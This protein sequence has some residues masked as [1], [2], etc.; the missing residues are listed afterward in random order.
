MQKTTTSL[1]IPPLFTDITIYHPLFPFVSF[2]SVDNPQQNT[3]SLINKTLAPSQLALSAVKAAIDHR[4]TNSP[5]SRQSSL[6]RE[7][8]ISPLTDQVPPSFSPGL[9]TPIL[10]SKTQ[11]ST[12]HQSISKGTLTRVD[13]FSVQSPSTPLPLISQGFSH[14][15]RLPST[16]SLSSTKQQRT[17]S[18]FELCMMQGITSNDAGKVSRSSR[19]SLIFTSQT[20]QKP[21]TDTVDEKKASLVHIL[22]SSFNLLLIL[23]PFLI[24]ESIL[25]LHTISLLPSSP[26]ILSKSTAASFINSLFSDPD[27][28]AFVFSITAPGLLPRITRKEDNTLESSKPQ[29]STPVPCVF[30]ELV[31]AYSSL[32]TLHNTDVLRSSSCL[33]LVSSQIVRSAE[34]AKPTSPPANR[35]LY[36]QYRLNRPKSPQSSVS[37]SSSGE[38]ATSTPLK[39]TNPVLLQIPSAF[40]FIFPFGESSDLS[41]NDLLVAVDVS[42][43]S[44][45]LHSLCI[46]RNRQDSSRLGRHDPGSITS[47]HVSS[48]T[49]DY[50]DMSS[51]ELAVI[52]KA[53]PFYVNSRLKQVKQPTISTLSPPDEN[54]SDDQSIN[55]DTEGV[56]DT[57]S[58]AQFVLVFHSIPQSFFRHLVSA[59]LHIATNMIISNADTLSDYRCPL[60]SPHTRHPSKPK[61]ETKKDH[62]P[63]PPSPRRNARSD[64]IGALSGAKLDSASLAL[65][66]SASIDLPFAKQTAALTLPSQTNQAPSPVASSPVVAPTAATYPRPK[67]PVQLK[68]N[69]YE[70]RFPKTLSFYSALIYRK[71]IHLAASCE[72]QD[73]LDIAI[74]SFSRVV[75]DSVQ[76]I[77]ST[78]TVSSQA[79]TD[80]ETLPDQSG[81]LNPPDDSLQSPSTGSGP[82]EA[83]TPGQSP[84]S[85]ISSSSSAQ[86]SVSFIS[87]ITQ[88]L[89][90]V[91]FSLTSSIS[92]PHQ[93]PVL[94]NSM[95]P[96]SDALS[97]NATINQAVSAYVLSTEQLFFALSLVRTALLD[98][99]Q[100]KDSWFLIY[101]VLIVAAR[102]IIISEPL[103]SKDSATF[104]S[105]FRSFDA[106]TCVFSRR[107][108]IDS[109]EKL[110]GIISTHFQPT[111]PRSSSA[112]PSAEDETEQTETHMVSYA[113]ISS[114]NSNLPPET[115]GSYI[116][117]IQNPIH[118]QKSKF[119]FRITP[120][121][122]PTVF[123]PFSS[124]PKPSPITSQEHH[125]VLLCPFCLGK[126]S[127]ARYCPLA[128]EPVEPSPLTV[129]PPTNAQESLPDPETILPQSPS[130]TPSPEMSEPEADYSPTDTFGQLLNELDDVGEEKVAFTFSFAS[131]DRKKRQS[132]AEDAMYYEN[133]VLKRVSS[134]ESMNNHS[135]SD[136]LNADPLS[137]SKPGQIKEF[138]PTLARDQFIDSFVDTSRPDLADEDAAISVFS[139]GIKDSL[140]LAC[141]SEQF[142]SINQVVFKNANVFTASLDE[143]NTLHLSFPTPFSAQPGEPADRSMVL[144][145]L[146]VLPPIEPSR[147]TEH[148]AQT[149][150][151]CR[152]LDLTRWNIHR[153]IL[154]LPQLLSLFRILSCSL[155]PYLRIAAVESV[156]L[157][158]DHAMRFLTYNEQNLIALFGDE[159]MMNDHQRCTIKYLLSFLNLLVRSNPFEDVRKHCFIVLRDLCDRWRSEFNEQEYDV[160]VSTIGSVLESVNDTDLKPDFITEKETTLPELADTKTTRFPLPDWPHPGEEIGVG[161]GPFAEVTSIHGP[162][163]AHI[164]LVCVDRITVKMSIELLESQHE[165]MVAFHR[166]LEAQP[167]ILSQTIPLSPTPLSESTLRSC[168]DLA[169]FIVLDSLEFLQPEHCVS[170]LTAIYAILFQV[171]ILQIQLSSVSVFTTIVEH[172]LTTHITQSQNEATRSR[173]QSDTLTFWSAF[174][175]GVHLLLNVMCATDYD[176]RSTAI[177]FFSNL[178]HVFKITSQKDALFAFSLIDRYIRSCKRL[179]NNGLVYHADIQRDPFLVPRALPSQHQVP[180]NITNQ[181]E[182][183]LS[184]AVTSAIHLCHVLL[185]KIDELRSSPFNGQSSMTLLPC[186]QY[187]ATRDSFLNDIWTSIWL[188]LHLFLEHSLGGCPHKR[189]LFSPFNFAQQICLIQTDVSKIAVSDRTSPNELQCSLC[190]HLSS[191]AMSVSLL[192]APFIPRA[193]PSPVFVQPTQSQIQA[194][195]DHILNSIIVGSHLKTDKPFID[196]FSQSVF[197]ETKRTSSSYL[198]KEDIFI[199]H[200]LQA[201]RPFG[202]PPIFIQDPPTGQTTPNQDDASGKDTDPLPSLLASLSSTLFHIDAHRRY[203]RNLPHLSRSLVDPLITL[204]ILTSAS[205]R[206]FKIARASMSQFT[207]TLLGDQ[208][209]RTVPSSLFAKTG[210]LISTSNR[211][212]TEFA[213]LEGNSTSQ[214]NSSVK[215]KSPKSEPNDT[216][217]DKSV[218]DVSVDSETMSL[219]PILTEDSTVDPAV[220]TQPDEE[221]VHPSE[222]SERTEEAMPMSETRLEST[223]NESDLIDMVSETRPSVEDVESEAK[224]SGFKSLLEKKSEPGREDDDTI[225]SSKSEPDMST[226]THKFSSHSIQQSDV[227]SKD[228]PSDEEPAVNAWYNSCGFYKL[229]KAEPQSPFPCCQTSTAGESESEHFEQLKAVPFSSMFPSLS[230]HQDISELIVLLS[231]IYTTALPFPRAFSSQSSSFTDSVTGNT[232]HKYE[233]PS[234]GPRLPYEELI[235]SDQS[236]ASERSSHEDTQ[237]PEPLSKGA[238]TG[239]HDVTWRF[240]QSH[241]PFYPHPT[242]ILKPELI[243]LSTN[244]QT[245]PV[246]FESSYSRDSLSI[247]FVHLFSLHSLSFMTP[248]ISF[249]KEKE[250]SNEQRDSL[251][252]SILAA[253]WRNLIYAIQSYRTLMTAIAGIG[254]PSLSVT[255][256]SIEDYINHTTPD[257]EDDRSRSESTS[258]SEQTAEGTPIA[259]RPHL[260]SSDVPTKR[261]LHSLLT[262]SKLISTTFEALSFI[263]HH[264]HPKHSVSVIVRIWRHLVYLICSSPIL[265]YSAVS[266]LCSLF[267]IVLNN[268]STIVSIQEDS[269]TSSKT[270]RQSLWF[271]FL[272]II[273]VFTRANLPPLPQLSSIISALPQSQLH[274]LPVL[275]SV[276]IPH[277]FGLFVTN[278]YGIT[279]TSDFQDFSEWNEL[280]HSF[281]KQSIQNYM[282][283][284]RNASQREVSEYS[285]GKKRM[286]S[287]S[288]KRKQLQRSHLAIV[289][290]KRGDNHPSM[291][292]THSEDDA[293]EALFEAP[294]KQLKQIKKVQKS[295]IH[296]ELFSLPAA[297][298]ILDLRAQEQTRTITRLNTPSFSETLPGCVRSKRFPSYTLPPKHSQ[299]IP[300]DVFCSLL[301]SILSGYGSTVM[302]VLKEKKQN[303]NANKM[304]SKDLNAI[305]SMLNVAR[306]TDPV[307][308]DP[309]ATSI[310]QA[311]QTLPGIT[312]TPKNS[313][314]KRYD[315]STLGQ[316][317]SD[318]VAPQ[319]EA[320]SLSSKTS[321]SPM[322][323][324]PK[325]KLNQNMSTTTLVILN[326]LLTACVIPIHSALFTPSFGTDSL[327]FDSQ[328][329]QSPENPP[330]SS[331][332][333]YSINDYLT[334]LDLSLSPSDTPSFDNTEANHSFLLDRFNVPI[335]FGTTRPTGSSL[336][337][338]DEESMTLLLRSLE[339]FIDQAATYVLDSMEEGTKDL[340][341]PEEV[342]GTIDGVSQFESDPIIEMNRQIV[343]SALFA[344]VH[345]SFILLIFS[346]PPPRN[347]PSI[348][349]RF[350]VAF[351][352]AHVSPA[353][354]SATRLFSLPNYSSSTSP[355]CESSLPFSHSIGCGLDIVS[356]LLSQTDKD[357]VGYRFTHSFVGTQH[358]FTSTLH[359]S[360]LI[361]FTVWPR[362]VVLMNS[363]LSIH[364]PYSDASHNTHRMIYFV[365]TR[366]AQSFFT[367]LDTLN[368]SDTVKTVLYG[369]WDSEQ[370]TMNQRLDTTS[371]TPVSHRCVPR[372]TPEISPLPH[373]DLVLYTSSPSHLL[374]FVF[375]LTH[376]LRRT[377]TI[378]GLMKELVLS[379]SPLTPPLKALCLAL[380]NKIESMISLNP[381]AASLL[382][383]EE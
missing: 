142:M 351:L 223:D 167:D 119:S 76:T 150:A 281:S 117:N 324:T 29:S 74:G 173:E 380:L 259:P 288:G 361:F 16:F 113:G 24:P 158:I 106:H 83:V 79:A 132:T 8:Y 366:L 176:I 111:L 81:D 373:T 382:F 213:N 317:Q 280:C 139:E 58:T 177:K 148:F 122:Y 202:T 356:S 36:I 80:S 159:D 360:E 359:P 5:E 64:T 198:T 38:P 46:L 125:N 270:L 346:D 251:E 69:F 146:I 23:G 168:V 227:E 258:T 156:R 32:L 205:S 85:S 191:K 175:F 70:G 345:H 335:L 84:F 267:E 244:A 314:F 263:L 34:V 4:I 250:I 72:C 381:S 318:S 169:H 30:V 328:F 20:T 165:G 300:R 22:V 320:S 338:S 260:G 310:Q 166:R 133:G 377:L 14:V 374:P 48:T 350:L 243:S 155:S 272:H 1:L 221:S 118:L 53:I 15:P 26:D 182:K 266:L 355:F 65:L 134:L 365:F 39:T 126:K 209:V 100:L 157:L 367:V 357:P 218:P 89:T 17:D 37:P 284:F 144:K 21:P 233:P 222:R 63:K 90:S 289:S 239:K 171:N 224:E 135:E 336:L 372:S 265:Q 246:V 199:P 120:I 12:Q 334:P 96:S 187:H 228:E 299:G 136:S 88:T 241:W 2:Q 87:S 124:G 164:L 257:P 294:R 207:Q 240:E 9:P 45:L 379:V 292:D 193:V 325:A 232:G 285:K 78:P 319:S 42:L 97:L 129:H 349:L 332:S 71:L 94:L 341:E 323:T 162:Q 109:S 160:I 10:D 276:S 47:G 183:S 247:Q 98:P 149:T 214:F 25:L 296:A 254:I 339:W 283:S 298:P 203:S 326:G 190:Q 210:L 44:Q 235:G 31:N 104:L 114:K 238:P 220:E 194:N 52:W 138:Y 61:A 226:S 62:P 201:F 242:Y 197:S 103:P 262:V 40:P 327:M 152:L 6:T 41:Q 186:Q 219:P 273:S 297:E 307:K 304:A 77:K 170:M 102:R 145:H 362:F 115:H 255:S 54:P 179:W 195:T 59:I 261:I 66:S 282:R 347:Y 301:N 200:N 271:L 342:R 67:K 237:A 309:L 330:D 290:L 108:L 211:E 354:P 91:S 275:S 161:F 181:F 269:N 302:V 178:M 35:T 358:S 287:F 121:L 86:P 331:F 141:S 369:Q 128:F 110:I 105:L 225:V 11:P 92:Q 293:P 151:L 163:T 18:L 43:P 196:T 13:T 329:I 33:K 322:K 248:T 19:F 312:D 256:D 316:S 127:N 172:C 217:L 123:S 252:L 185:F 303:P 278:L 295:D 291:E 321:F 376:I 51:H 215:P 363:M 268:T 206:T 371:S 95:L 375:L 249:L 306:A 231:M 368:P 147:T 75:L 277:F 143:T 93:Q 343:S 352:F 180:T 236:Q 234:Y 50:S 3:T 253:V 192:I 212:Q 264:I 348:P 274:P 60:Q 140:Q 116:R 378:K 28:L 188:S 184:D 315:A 279:D 353:I 153:V 337:R 137:A 174:I 313:P 130:P 204:S 68:S 73:V 99:V 112:W 55:S 383:H 364:L 305:Y 154:L 344:K 308:G 245:Y 7:L 27:L 230:N 286:E 208:Y 311:T 340:A 370:H 216:Q 56:E 189:K 131:R 57:N 333:S 101:P 49:L 107:N 82:S 229:R